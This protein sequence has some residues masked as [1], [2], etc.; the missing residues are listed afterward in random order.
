MLILSQISLLMRW[1]CI[2]QLIMNGE[3]AK[4]SKMWQQNINDRFQTFI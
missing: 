4:H 1:I 3:L 2:K